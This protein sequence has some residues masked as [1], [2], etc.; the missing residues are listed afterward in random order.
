M[1]RFF[2]GIA[3]VTGTMPDALLAQQSAPARAPRTAQ[4]P[5]DDEG[6]DVA[7]VTVSTG[8][9]LPGSAIG[10][11]PP[12]QQLSPAE[13][14][15]YGVSSVGDLL[16]E[17]GPQLRSG[18]GNGPPVVLLNGRRIS[19]FEEIRNLPAEA[20]LRVDILP[21]EV[22]LKYGFSA[23]QRVIN[24]VLRPRFRAVTTELEGRVATEGGRATP[25]GRFDILALNRRGRVNLHVEYQES[26]ALTEAERG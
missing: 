22:A 20:I 17:L 25:A 6:E 12:D 2:F 11:I 23:D 10:D 26:S 3:L 15:S 8:R 4:Q 13:I 14:R 18:R 5:V 9:N 24:F 16:V 21:E 19:G 7:E 1:R